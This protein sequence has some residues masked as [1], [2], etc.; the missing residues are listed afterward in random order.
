MA[1]KADKK[2]LHAVLQPRKPGLF[3]KLPM[4]VIQVRIPM[5][6]ARMLLIVNASYAKGRR[7][8]GRCSCGGTSQWRHTS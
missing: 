4:H 5:G 1:K 6:S 7:R 2:L 8:S 3:S